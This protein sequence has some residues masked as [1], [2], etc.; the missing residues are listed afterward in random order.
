M[1]NRIFDPRFAHPCRNAG[2]QAQSRLGATQLDSTRAAESIHRLSHVMPQRPNQ[3]NRLVT[4]LPPPFG[5]IYLYAVQRSSLLLNYR[6]VIHWYKKKTRE[7]RK[8]KPQVLSVKPR[9]LFF[10]RFSSP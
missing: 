8:K 2:R 5:F 10:S 9:N 3:P 6:F 7:R 4:R 1:E